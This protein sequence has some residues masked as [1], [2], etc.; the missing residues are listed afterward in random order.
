M[1]IINIDRY[2]SKIKTGDKINSIWVSLDIKQK[3]GGR[4]KLALP[5]DNNN[6]KNW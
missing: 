2:K 1:F 5:P 4:A 3:E 6:N